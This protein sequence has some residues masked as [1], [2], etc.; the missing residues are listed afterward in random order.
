MGAHRGSRQKEEQSKMMRKTS[1][2]RRQSQVR[3]NKGDENRRACDTT[4]HF[5]GGLVMRALYCG[6]KR[7]LRMLSV[8]LGLV[9]I[10][11]ARPRSAG[12]AFALQPVDGVVVPFSQL[13]S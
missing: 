8:G 10:K 13:K 7:R 5:F 6:D 2:N 12:R 1:N 4:A 9:K 3:P 11:G